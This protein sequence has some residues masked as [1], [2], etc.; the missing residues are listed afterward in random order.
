MRWT[1]GLR[2]PY[3]SLFGLLL[4]ASLLPSHVAA[5]CFGIV[6]E[7]PGSESAVW[8]LQIQVRTPGGLLRL[9]TLGFHPDA[10]DGYDEGFD[11]WEP[12]GNFEPGEGNE[13]DLFAFFYYPENAEPGTDIFP[14]TVGLRT[15]IIEPK[16]DMSWPLRV[17]YG[18]REPTNIT[19]RWDS[20]VAADLP[21]YA[22]ELVTP[23]D[24]VILMP[25]VSSYTFPASRGSYSF[26]IHA[27]GEAEAEAASPGPDTL[28]LVGAI[29]AYALVVA[30]ILGLR[31]Q[32]VRRGRG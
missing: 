11:F 24:E 12:L 13:L 6:G 29:A 19:L 8:S 21:G 22:V 16:G 20:A 14:V 32:K 4:L 5:R 7:S 9:A 17:A 3:L 25:E 27:H 10:T 15:S 23:F 28:V 26:S 1:P 30:I 2:I 31:L 18:L